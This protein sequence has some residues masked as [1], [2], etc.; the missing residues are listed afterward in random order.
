[1]SKTSVRTCWC[2]T[3]NSPQEHEI[4]YKGTKQKKDGVYVKYLSNCQRCQFRWEHRIISTY[5]V[6]FHVI[7]INDY[8]ALIQMEIYAPLK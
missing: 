5:N 1:M 6:G 2:D 3:C 7:P 8:N 4:I